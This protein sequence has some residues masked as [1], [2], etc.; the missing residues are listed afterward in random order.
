MIDF[1]FLVMLLKIYEVWKEEDLIFSQIFPL[2]WRF[3]IH[4]SSSNKPEVTWSGSG[5]E[6]TQVKGEVVTCKCNY[7]SLRSYS[8]QV[9]VR[10][11]FKFVLD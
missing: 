6:V 4:F 7:K 8:V 1:S 2:E 10:L 11:F 9:C 5:C 3:M